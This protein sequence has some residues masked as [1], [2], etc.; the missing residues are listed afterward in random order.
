M[1]KDLTNRESEQDQF[2]GALE[3]VLREGARRLLQQAVEE[4]V[5][6]YI[7]QHSH[8]LDESGHR[9]VTRNGYLPTRNIQTGLGPIEVSRPRVRDNRNSERFSSAILPKYARRVP[10]VEAVIPTLYLKGVSTGDFSEAL[11]ALL[12]KNAQGLSPSNIVRLKKV[13]EQEYEDWQ[14]RDLS[15]KKYV[16][17]WVDGIYSNVRLTDDRPCILVALGALS[18]GTKELIAVWDGQRESKLSWSEVIQDLKKRGLKAG[19]K[20]A[21]GDGALGFWAAL[22]EIFPETCQQRC[23]V[24]KTANIL[25]KLPKSVQPSAKQLIHEMYMAQNKSDALKAFRCFLKTYEERYP[26][27]CKCLKK[28]EDQLFTFYDFPAS[29]WC[30]IRTTNPIESTFATIRHRTRQTKGCGSRKATLTMVYKL[31]REAEKSWNRLRGYQLIDKVMKGVIFK[32]GDEVK[33]QAA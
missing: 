11:E 20:L 14:K 21:I 24:H 16:Y 5:E 12:G 30:H 7:Q 22:E 28:D 23:W 10:S 15:G 18:D 32:D 33:E 25:D 2:N 9:E 6:A 4:E 1:D 13:W 3:S 19:P 17:M 8:A 27:A 29:H 31:A 26:R